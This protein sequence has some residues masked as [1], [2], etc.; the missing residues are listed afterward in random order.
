VHKVGF[1]LES[2]GRNFGDGAGFFVKFRLGFLV[3]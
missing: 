2:G 1:K 3:G